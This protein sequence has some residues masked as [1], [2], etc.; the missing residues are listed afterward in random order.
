M[1]HTGTPMGLKDDQAEEEKRD[2]DS[3][4]ERPHQSLC[5]HSTGVRTA[6]TKTQA[7]RRMH[8]ETGAKTPSW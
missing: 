1:K 2:L 6:Q 5:Q 7:A 3:Q 8:M 4:S